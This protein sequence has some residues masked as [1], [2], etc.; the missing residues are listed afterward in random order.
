MLHFQAYSSGRGA[1]I[2]VTGGAG[3]IGS[4]LVKRLNDQSYTEILVVDNLANGEKSH[5]ISL[6]SA[7]PAPWHGAMDTGNAAF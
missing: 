2:I 7:I 6:I 3:F 1:I 5:L 4:N